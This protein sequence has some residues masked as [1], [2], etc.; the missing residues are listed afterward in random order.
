MLASTCKLYLQVA[1]H[2]SDRQGAKQTAEGGLNKNPMLGFLRGLGTL[3]NE[4]LWK[5]DCHKHCSRFNYHDDNPNVF[6]VPMC[7]VSFVQALA[8]ESSSR[9]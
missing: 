2:N 1:G 8:S 3:P 4:R 7:I 6:N 9:A 5:L